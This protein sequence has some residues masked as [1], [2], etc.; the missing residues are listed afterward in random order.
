[1]DKKEICL[2]F[3]RRV[4]CIITITIIVLLLLFVQSKPKLQEALQLPLLP[5]WDTATM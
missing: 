4:V 5:S 2:K 3:P 1:M